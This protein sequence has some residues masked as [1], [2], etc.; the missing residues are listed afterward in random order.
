GI[1]PETLVENFLKNIKEK[2]I[3]NLVLILEKLEKEGFDLNTFWKEMLEKLHTHLINLS[4]DEKDSIF[5]K[6]EIKD[7]IYI[8]SVFNKSI[9]EARRH[10]QPK[11][12]Y[13]LAVLKLKFLKDLRSLEDILK[14]GIKIADNQRI[15]ASPETEKENKGFD[16]ANAILKVGKEAGGIVASALKKAKIEEREDHFL[17]LLDESIYKIVEAKLEIIQKHFPKP[18]KIEK[19]KSTNTKTSKSKK[20]DES[21]D[22][23][24]E[25]FEGKIMSYKEQ[26]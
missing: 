14:N 7:L 24:L 5:S 11:H 26:S 2:N 8:Q 3:K 19:V 21:V 10:F 25:L 13:Q 22:K 20:R 1:V 6:E 12:I 18:L 23:V 17:L 15:S 16:I 9:Y 4:L